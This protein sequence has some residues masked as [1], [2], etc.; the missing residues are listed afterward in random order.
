MPDAPTM[1]LVLRRNSIER[2]KREKF[3]FALMDELPE[4]IARGYEDIS[5]EDMVRFTWYGLYHDK[6]KMGS[7]MMRV[8]VPS[9]ILTPQQFRTIGELSRRF[10]RNDGELTTR[11]NVQLHW[12]ELVHLPDIFETFSS[13]GLT[14]TGACGDTVRNVT[15]CPVA[16]IDHNEL[17]DA[18]PL[19]HEAAE[20][21]SGNREY[22][23]LPRKHKITISTCAHHCNAPA[24]N[25]IALVGVIH[26]GRPGY[27]VRVGGGLSSAPRIS[28]H[29]DVFVP[30]AEALE[31][32]RAI[33]DAWRTNMQY[34]MS[35]AKA[36][37]KFMVDD[38][39]VDGMRAE[40]ETQLGR[41]LED[42]PFVPQRLSDTEH[43]GIHPQ[44]QEGLSYIGF[45]AYLGRISGDQMVRIADIA[46]S[47][48]GDIRLTRHQNFIVANVPDGEVERVVDAV[49]EVG[50]PLEVNRLRGTSLGCTGAPLCNYAVAETKT[51]LDEIVQHLEGTFGHDAEGIVVNVDGCPHACAQHWVADIGLQ[52]STLRSRDSSGA[53]T[54][55]IEAYEIY[56]RGSLGEEAAIG[57]P[58]VRR[59]PHT[60]AKFYVGRLVGSYL[61]KR[62][63]EESFS[64]FADRQSDEELI[65]T[66]SDRSL[67]EVTA[68][69]AAKG[70]RGAVAVE[71]A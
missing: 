10:G 1:E 4:L 41:R 50:F 32:L 59:V 48:G 5:E 13:V 34:R 14:T 70:R 16:G 57:R 71:S 65:A 31:V 18:T 42:L 67:E 45:P 55:K 43:L 35:R 30:E 69:L 60:E 54:G 63:P 56:L 9:G 51:K 28:Q 21:F 38:Y 64:D 52:G 15:G 33:L 23:D 58:I 29:L 61:D 25:C 27:A 26:E 49:A 12:I 3:P 17:F 62:L 68:E 22:S 44:K 7:F 37:L 6:P 20:F 19:V 36:R 8:K 46:D 40:V 66:A 24:I 11:Q 39:G 47:V 53:S 2:L